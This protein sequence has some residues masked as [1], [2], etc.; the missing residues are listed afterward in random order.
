MV[1]VT[2]E[3]IYEVLE[4]MQARLSNIEHIQGEMKIELRAIRGHLNAMQT[5]IAS[6]YNSVDA[7]SNRVDRIEK[8]LELNDAPVL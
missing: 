6:L 4:P 5:D 7:L 3:L 2:N 8:R 1:E